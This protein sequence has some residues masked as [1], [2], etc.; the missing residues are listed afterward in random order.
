MF[1]FYISLYF[2]LFLY[3]FFTFFHTLF[4]TC[5]PRYIASPPFFYWR[6]INIPKQC[7]N[8]NDR[9]QNIYKKYFE[10][11]DFP[12]RAP[13]K[14]LQKLKPIQLNTTEFFFQNQ[15]YFKVKKF[16]DSGGFN[17]GVYLYKTKS[18][19]HSLIVKTGMK[20]L[21]VQISHKLHESQFSP[22]VFHLGPSFMITEHVGT[23]IDKQE[24]KLTKNEMSCVNFIVFEIMKYIHKE[25]KIYHCD[26]FFTQILMNKNFKI[27][28]IDWGHAEY[29]YGFDSDLKKYAC[30]FR[31][32]NHNWSKN[33]HGQD[34]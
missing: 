19:S 26:L 3:L 27:T 28:I 29:V 31:Q 2:V 22:K 17:S 16:G 32:Y 25:Y 9:S 11:K 34:L 10:T 14:N 7:N 5:I 13:F 30:K 23:R 18:G 1:P 8:S 33:L 21:E 12:S 24:P 4:G 20:D 15:K 6:F